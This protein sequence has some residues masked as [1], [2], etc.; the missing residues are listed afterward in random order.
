VS[1]HL[2]LHPAARLERTD[3]ALVLR[4]WG[5]RCT[6]GQ[7]SPGIARALNT[8]ATTGAAEDALD[9]MVVDTDGPAFLPHWLHTLDLVRDAGAL[10]YTLRRAGG[11]FAA[12][13]AAAPASHTQPLELPPDTAIALSRFAYLR[14]VNGTLV[15]ASPRS[16]AAIELCDPLAAAVVAALRRPCHV[17]SVAAAV[18][19]VDSETVTKFLSLVAAASMLADPASEDG[20]ADANM[21][22]W[23]FVDLLFHWRSR[24]GLHALPTGGT[25]PLR[26]RSSPLPVV[27][28]AMPG[29]TIA[30]AR[31]DPRQLA[32]TDL[33]FSAVLDT[34]RSVRAYGDDPLTRDQLGTFLFRAAR[35]RRVMDGD[36]QLPYAISERP[37]PSGGACYPL[38][39]YPVVA[40]CDGL[41]RGLYHYDPL[42]HCLT[43]IAAWDDR[44]AGLVSDARRA[45][46]AG[47]PQVLLVL[48]ARF[49]RVM[50]KYEGMAYA[51]ILKDLGVLYQ[52]MYLV[53]TAMGLAPCALGCGDTK[54]FARITGLDPYEES[55][56]GEF[57]LGSRVVAA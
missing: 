39:I 10:R 40:A 52:T 34:R 15:L 47:A 13:V 46:D 57:L 35:I 5:Q 16:P 48:T 31:P 30:L 6:F 23:G 21:D 3:A 43:R 41:E 25:F 7:P 9:A 4:H 28:P 33:P 24:W 29:P 12:L 53:A 38:E 32:A 22:Q 17:G 2:A 11:D 1:Y 36:E 50:W 55:S 56:V 27:K 54:A 44:V 49:R 18:P 26:G 14:V 8:L 37:Y 51:T 20:R 42:G 45:D 19:M